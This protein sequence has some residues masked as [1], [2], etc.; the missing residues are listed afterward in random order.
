MGEYARGNVHINNC[1][2]RT[3]NPEAVVICFKGQVAG[4]G[5]LSEG[6]QIALYRISHVRTL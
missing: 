5:I 4:G 3:I 2:N 6:N 1:E